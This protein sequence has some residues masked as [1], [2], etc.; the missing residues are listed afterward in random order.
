MPAKKTPA[1]K[2]APVK[3]TVAKKA[4]V[5]KVDPKKPVLTGKNLNIFND[6]KE[7]LSHCNNVT[8]ISELG[9]GNRQSHVTRDVPDEKIITYIKNNDVKYVRGVINGQEVERKHY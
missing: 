8:I 7:M 1:P 9:N 3:K 2:K 5:K 6:I 4:P